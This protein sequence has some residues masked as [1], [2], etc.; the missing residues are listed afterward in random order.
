MLYQQTSD[1]IG[2]ICMWGRHVFMGY[3]DKQEETN[4]VIDE[5]GWLH[6]GDLGL[7]DNQGY[8]YITGRIKGTRLGPA[9]ISCKQAPPSMSGAGIPAPTKASALCLVW[10]RGITWVHRASCSAHPSSVL[11]NSRWPSAGWTR[12]SRPP[13]P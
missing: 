13:R 7:M 8:L 9:G 1:G 12:E 10:G 2:E 4:E 6:S 11:E 5:E 3:L